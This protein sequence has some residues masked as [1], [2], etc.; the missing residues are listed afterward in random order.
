[1]HREEFDGKMVQ[2]LPKTLAHGDGVACDR[3]RLQPDVRRREKIPTASAFA[4]LSP[5]LHFGVTRRRDTS[6]VSRAP[7][8]S[9]VRGDFFVEPP[10]KNPKPRRGRSMPLLTELA[11]LGWSR[12]TN[13]PRLQRF[14]SRGWCIS[15]LKKRLAEHGFHFIE[16]PRRFALR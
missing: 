1:M 15:R 6:A 7:S 9:P 13:M 16:L 12:A 4:A 10:A 3:F 5:S 14:G 2:M 11:A 8:P